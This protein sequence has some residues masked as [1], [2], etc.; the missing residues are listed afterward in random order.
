MPK[1]GEFDTDHDALVKRVDT[2]T[3]YGNVEL[4]DWIFDK[5]DIQNNNN[6]LDIGCGFGKQ[7][8]PLIEKG[9][10]VTAIDASAPA[11]DSLMERV[12]SPKLNSIVC[13]FDN[14][15]FLPNDH[16]DKVISSYA[17]YYS[18]DRENLLTKIENSMRTN[19]SIFICGPSRQNNLEIKKFLRDIGV[20]FGEGSAPFMDDIAPSLFEKKFGNVETTILENKLVFPSAEEVWNYW[21]SHNMFNKSIENKFQEALFGHFKS[22]QTFVLTKIIKGIFSIKTK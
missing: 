15:D 7:T 11:I 16:F 18:I 12:K 9:C 6:I 8:I 3:K 13:E 10:S 22:N 21:S 2:H 17:F 19:A 4:N 20:E 1:I 5:L 14:I